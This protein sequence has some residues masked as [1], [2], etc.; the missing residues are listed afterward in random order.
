MRSILSLTLLIA[1]PAFAGAQ[2]LAAEPPA[3]PKPDPM[4]R[5]CDAFGPGYQLVPGTTTCIKI[6]GYVRSSITFGDK[7]GSG[8]FVPGPASG[9]RPAKPR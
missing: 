1:G 7:A 3:E 6:G 5:I 9:S 2:A 4:A 8:D